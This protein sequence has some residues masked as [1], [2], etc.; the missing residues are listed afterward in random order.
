MLTAGQLLN[1]VKHRL[2][3]P[4][5]SE[6]GGPMRVLNLAGQWLDSIHTWQQKLRVSA[7]LDFTAGTTTLTLPANVKEIIAAEQPNTTSNGRSVCWVGPSDML[8]M[9]EGQAQW[10]TF[11][12]YVSIESSGTAWTLGIFQPPGTNTTDILTISYY[13]GWT[14][15]VNDKDV[16]TVHPS[17]EPLLFLVVREF[18]AGVELHDLDQRMLAIENGSMI[19]AAKRADASGSRMLGPLEGGGVN[20]VAQV[21]DPWR[22][23]SQVLPS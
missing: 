8:R 15:L 21:W 22:I 7:S 11:D 9:R 23:E 5:A 20:S 19:R 17:L 6:L 18:A 2:A 13:A 14:N 4:T 1:D 12:L 3:G 16:V 10:E